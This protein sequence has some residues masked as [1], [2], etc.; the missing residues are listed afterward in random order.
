MDLDDMDLDADDVKDVDGVK[1]VGDEDLEDINRFYD[2]VTDER[3]EIE[4]RIDTDKW[5]ID[6]F[7]KTYADY[8]R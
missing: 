3:R 5:Y 6:N 8:W 7:G 4:R 2:E 1:D